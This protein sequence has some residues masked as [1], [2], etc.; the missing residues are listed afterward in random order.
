[1]EEDGEGLDMYSIELKNIC[2]RIETFELK[3]INLSIPRGS[4]IG[5][6]GKNGA[7]KTTLFKTLM[8]THLK[9]DG[10]MY[11]NGF[12]YE[13][14]EKEIRESIAIVHDTMNVNPFTK[15]K[16]LYK[17]N[18][19]MYPNFDDQYFLSLSDELNIPLDKK[20]NKMSL[21]MQK[22]LSIAIALSLKPNILLLDE[23]FIGIDPIDKQK[24][25]K[26]VQAFMEDENRTVLISSHYVEDIEKI[27]DYIAIID[28]G[29]IKVFQDK[30]AILDEYVYVKLNKDQD[31]GQ[32]IMY[33]KHTSFGIEGLMIKEQAIN[34]NIQHHRPTLEEIFILMSERGDA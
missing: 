30:D 32:H 10:H 2:A 8:G 5:L 19:M 34:D 16:R 22:K 23:P 33:S 1:M 6:L 31:S 12:T 3:N 4:I 29:E 7:G 13:S 27:S 17:Y 14:N 21:G 18:K 9:Y 24:L 11:I 28:N 15:G 26:H 25:M 20:M